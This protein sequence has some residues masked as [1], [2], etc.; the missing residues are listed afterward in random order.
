MI[1]ITPW[2][3]KKLQKYVLFQSPRVSLPLS[4]DIINIAYFLTIAKINATELSSS[5]VLSMLKESVIE[6]A[7]HWSVTNEMFNEFSYW[8]FFHFRTETIKMD[9]FAAVPRDTPNV[10]LE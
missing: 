9:G 2:F 5:K 7:L 6:V 4:A 1:K 10:C 3:H 8:T